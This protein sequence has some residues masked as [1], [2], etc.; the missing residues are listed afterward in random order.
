[1]TRKPDQVF[2]SY[3]AEDREWASQFA[4]S[5]AAANVGLWS[6]DSQLRPGDDWRAKLA[7]ALRESRT[8]VLVL[9]RKSI[10]SP[11]VAF[12]WGAALADD[13]RII[14]VLVEDIPLEDLPPFVRTRQFLSALPPEEAGRQIAD[15]L[16][17]EAA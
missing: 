16:Q 6:A 13:K 9:S 14:P 1:M 15:L 17:A 8:I 3:N 5:L 2:L 4:R 12:E 7:E 11:W 10:A